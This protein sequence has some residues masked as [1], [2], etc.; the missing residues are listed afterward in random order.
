MERQPAVVTTDKGTADKGTTGRPTDARRHRP[1]GRGA[2][3]TAGT[4]AA[5][6]TGL[7]FTLLGVGSADRALAGFDASS[8]LW[9]STRSELARVNGI[10]GRVDTRVGVADAQAHQTQV[11]Q[12]DQFL[13]L[14]DLATGRISSL[15]LATLQIDATTRATN[16]LGVRVALHGDAAFVIDAVQ[17]TV[18]QLDP[19]SLRPMGQPIQYPPGL[20]G[21]FFDGTGRL[22]VGV[23][24]E[25]TVSA[26][27]AA[28]LP[29]MPE[30]PADDVADP[31][32][33]AGSG[34]GT[35]GPGPTT[36]RTEAVAPPSNELALTALDD[37]VAVLNRT[38]ATLTVLHD[39]SRRQVSLDLRGPATVPP[40]STGEPIAVTVPDDRRILLVTGDDVREITV[41]GRGSTLRPALAWAG[42]VYC[43][44]ERTR[45]IFAFDG[46]GAELDTIS[47]PEANGP[48]DLE[49]RENHLFINA[50]DASSARVVDDRHEVRAVDKYANGVL[51]GDPPPAP[52]PA[53]PPPPPAAGPPGAPREVSAAAADATVRVSWRAAPDNGAAITRYVV[54]GDGRTFDVGAN[55]RSFEVTGLTNGETYRFSVHAVNAEGRGPARRSNPVVPTA[56]VPTAPAEV[57]AEASPDGS[58]RVDW[59]ASDGQGAEIIGYVVT[60]VS[61]D[62]AVPADEPAGTGTIL[63]AGT[64]DYGTQYAFT[65]VAVNDRGAHSEASPLSN[66]V[67]P[68]T[69]PGEPVTLTATTVA[70]QRGVI[71]VD[72]T[73]AQGNGRPVTGYVVHAGDRRT[74]VATGTE[75]TV[76]GLGDGADVTVTVHARNEAG[77]GPPATATART[78][79]VPRVTITGAS[80][81]TGSITVAFTVDSGGGQTTCSAV[82]DGGRA[83]GGDCDSIRV[84]GLY[85]GRSYTVTVRADN[86]AGAGTATRA[87]VTTDLFGVATCV[88]GP[89]GDQRTYCDADVPGRN[90]NEIFSVPQ[91]DDSRQV[92]WV[93]NGSRLQ[94]LCRVPGQHVD[95]WIY[96]G[97]KASTWWIRV[98]YDGQNYLPWAWLNL[99]GGDR[100]DALPIC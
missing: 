37:G 66:T 68:F 55:Q 7:G 27:T 33:A 89:D 19:R 14:R 30:T 50:P 31:P 86:V 56:E 29:E 57:T 78:V 5:L 100:L 96:N 61:A 1:P 3:V 80:A 2:L 83:V 41:P 46:N 73:P 22:W 42:R 24:S 62:S 88:N 59:S 6:V 97:H 15:N 94:A 72:W 4:I 32:D 63:P 77:D 90:G 95:A 47:I 17:G 69:T 21:G 85:P 84:S 25:G 54:S 82:A 10:T 34:T 35:G 53:P 99:A 39:D 92:G 12:T 74:E 11:V 67:V 26:I 58:V 98:A 60:A 65:V 44:D 13:L 28:P 36:V 23:P 93:P 16:G 71:R 43:A 9:S 48:L 87:Q 38:T 52:P 51:G 64:L 75:V 45:E 70:D 91:Q 40:R 18:R 20:A 76:A 49:V 8:W 79:A 81:D